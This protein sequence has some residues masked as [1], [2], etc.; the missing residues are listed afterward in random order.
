MILN[1]RAEENTMNLVS[2]FIQMN[3][4]YTGHDYRKPKLFLFSGVKKN[5]IPL[6]YAKG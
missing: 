1:Y 5:G 2:F 6:L 4:E 3:G